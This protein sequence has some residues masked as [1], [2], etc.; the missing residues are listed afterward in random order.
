M[1]DLTYEYPAE[2]VMQRA[3]ETR[4]MIE[5][6]ERLRELAELARSRALL[7]NRGCDDQALADEI[8]G[9]LGQILGPLPGDAAR[10]EADRGLAGE[11]ERL[12][13][14]L[15]EV[16]RYGL[17]VAGCAEAYGEQES[18]H[19]WNEIAAIAEAALW[20]IAALSGGSAVPGRATR[21]SGGGR[22]NDVV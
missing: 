16:H 22:E 11:V 7:L 15:E 8:L 14:A 17:N 10:A 18:A 4:A 1:S 21:A 19:L 13:K 6:N 20:P 5:E 3:R 12:R 9:F 2:V